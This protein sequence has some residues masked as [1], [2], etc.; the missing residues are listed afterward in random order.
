M[1]QVAI[2]IDELVWYG[3]LPLDEASLQLALQQAVAQRLQA[4]GL[5]PAWQPGA[6][7][8][9]AEVTTTPTQRTPAG[10]VQALAAAIVGPPPPPGTAS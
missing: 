5:P 7:L 1:T 4:Q 10:I 9:Q 3:P 8:T 2:V 6:A